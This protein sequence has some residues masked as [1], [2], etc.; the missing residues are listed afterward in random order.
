MGTA[1]SVAEVEG[2]G[3]AFAR[4]ESEFRRFADQ[5]WANQGPDAFD[6]NYYDRAMIYY[7]WWARTGNPTYLE[8]AN[9][10]AV[11]YRRDY[12]EARNFVVLPH[13][14]ML[15]GVALHYLVTGDEASRTAVG[16]VADRL[17]RPG[18]LP[19]LADPGAEID[20]RVQARILTALILAR[21]LDAPSQAGHDWSARARE[22]LNNV[23]Q[24]QAP[25]GAY[26][27]THPGA[28]QCGYNKPWMVGLLN[29]AL[30]R[31]YTTFE[32]DGRIVGSVRRAVD[33]MWERNWDAGN[34][35]FVYLEGHC[36]GDG[37][38][39]AGDINNLISSGFG[40]VYRQTGDAT[41]R[42]RGDAV[43]AGGVVNAW[44]PISKQ[45]NQQY[46]SSYR[47]LSYR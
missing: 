46:T 44:L 45:F 41:Y 30:V 18:Q 23:L 24:S 33:Y 37:P 21:R 22:A 36:N 31:Y 8:R 25:D 3:G 16:R 17:I 38:I 19:V 32:A 9:A 34:Q 1:P 5:H 43:F 20:N 4:Y 40:F 7:V 12:L 28:G 29:D 13:E 42:T 6:G 26:R 2:W 14:A 27:F 39:Q 11:Q 35:G 10:H 15:D 47:Y